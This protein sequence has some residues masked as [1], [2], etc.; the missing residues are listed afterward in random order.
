M[1]RGWRKRLA[2]VAAAIAL[3]ACGGPAGADR[4]TGGFEPWDKPG[5]VLTF[6]DEF[7][8]TTLDT[9]AWSRR[10]HWGEAV[11]N[12][13]LQ[14]YVD[15]AFRLEGGVLSIVGERRGGRYAGEGMDY[16]SG[17]IA[18][19]H[20]QQY[21]WFEIRCR[22]PAGRGYWPAF[23]LLGNTS[24]NEIDVLESLG[25]E[26]TVVYTTVHWGTDYADDHHSDGA[27]FRGADFSS[28][29]HVF[30]VEWDDGKIVWWV[31]GRE[32]FRHTGAGVPRVPLY[33]ITNLAIGGNWPGPPDATTP[34]P[35]RLQID[36]I[37]VY[38]RGS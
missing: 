11:I 10:F 4:P 14:A 26:P 27:A 7:D 13:E 22:L 5:W 17:V 18:S 2:A 15:D 31:D 23:W 33:V 28:D 21:G 19:N 38:R 9:T 30:A 37:R 16:T 32:V 8:G 20:Y 12:G 35:G 24:I 34:F 1:S 29:F 3:P 6:H 36:Y 25:H